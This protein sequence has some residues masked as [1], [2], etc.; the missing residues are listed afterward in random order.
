MKGYLKRNVVLVAFLAI[1]LAL[2]A[3]MICLTVSERNA[4]AAENFTKAGEVSVGH[5]T[6]THYYPFRLCYTDGSAIE[7]DD[8]DYFYNY[9][10]DKSTKMWLE[11]EMI[12]DA[13]LASFAANAPDCVLVSGD[14]AQDGE[15]LGHIDMA[16]KLRKLQNAIRAQ[17]GKENFQI[18][19]VM[20][21]HDLY[22][23]DTF[24][25]DNATGTKTTFYYTTRL[26]AVKIYA[27]LGYPNMTADEATAFYGGLDSN[28]L[29]AGYGY[30][31]SDLSADYA[32]C[33]EFTTDDADGGER[34]FTVNENNKDLIT[35]AKFLA[36]GIIEVE[37]VSRSLAAT[38]GLCYSY[39]KF[40]D[41]KDIGLG[42]MSTVAV[43]ND[44]KFT[45]LALDVVQ[46]NVE[47]G[48][49][50]GGQLHF[51]TWD[52]LE[53]L[54]S[55]ARPN[56][57]AT[58][59]VA[60]A[61]HSLIPHWDMEEDITTGFI[62]YNWV[63]VS[64]FLADY[65]VRYVYTGHQ[66]AN[67]TVSR[68]SFNGNQITDMESS[69]H[70]SVGSQVKV[71]KVEYG[72]AD[73]K[74]AEK[75]Y[76]YAYQNVK[77]DAQSDI[78]LYDR[79]FKDD[80]FGYVAKNNLGEFINDETKEITNYSAYAQRRV[81]DNIVTN[82]VNQFLKPE[83]TEM[84]R[85]LVSD[86]SFNLGPL[87][88]DLG[89]FAGDIVQ[90]A[91]NLISEVNV[92]ILADYEYKGGTERFKPADMKLFGYLEEM[93]FGVLYGEV[94]QGTNVFTVFM[95]SY[96]RHCTGDNWI[97]FNDMPEAYRAVLEK[98]LS[99]EFVDMLFGA[100]LDR[101][102]GLMRLIEGLASTSL[103]LSKDLSRDFTNLINSVVSVLG[104][105]DVNLASF[106]LGAIV[107]AAG[108]IGMITD[109][110][111]G[112]GVK[113]DLAN[114][115]L[116]EIVDDIVAK[117]LTDSFK[118]GL[119]EYAY[120]IVVAFGCDG[121]HVDVKNDEGKLITVYKDEAY[122]FISKERA[123]EITVANGKQPSM[124]TTNF[125]SDPATQR[126]F[127][128]FTD[129]RVT[130]G[131]I[132]YTA[133]LENKTGVTTKDAATAIY[134]T[135][136]PLIDLGIWCQTGY[137]ELSRHTVELTGLTPDTTY[138][139]RAGS[140]DKGYWSEWHT[141]TTAAENGGFEVLVAS[142]LQSSTASAYQRIDSVYREVLASQFAGGLDFLI[143]PGDV[144]DNSRNL[145]HFRWFIDSS[146][147]IYAN[148]PM[149][150]APGN[151]DE[152]H[153]ELD[154]ASHAEY[155]GVSQDAVVTEYNYLWSHYNLVLTESQKQQSGFYY[156]F[157]YSGV[158]FVVLNTNDI[159]TEKVGDA[160]VSKLGQT[161]FN[162][163]V[164]DLAASDAKY[165][166]VI[167]HK[168]LYSEGSHSYD[169]DV[170]G[171]RAQLTP[172]FAEYGVNLVLAGHD[173][174]YNETFYLDA[175]GKKVRTNA[176][177]KNEI[178]D[179]GTLYVT[180]GTLG[181]KFYNYVD[182]PDVP[183]NVGEKLHTD[184]GKL[185]DPTYGKLVFDGEKLYYYG[186]QYLREMSDDGRTVTG[187]QSIEIKKG[188][189]VNAIIAISI[190]SIAAAAV[191]AVVVVVIVKKK[192]AAKSEA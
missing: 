71:T 108:G 4:E 184:D 40:N 98:V 58:L 190:V 132:Q 51:S 168:S 6:D 95:D 159:V 80:K 180:M 23:P 130:D 78:P 41:G 37:D 179:A 153:F 146:A 178:S 111:D 7:T 32:Y 17:S 118:Q 82:Y 157:D 177:K 2:C 68:I 88:I 185:A 110:I 49:V 1:I 93:V 81:Y 48:H 127:T 137:V 14:V 161:Q 192:K 163:L 73:G 116:P 135:T 145:S 175:N 86:L 173:H 142:D 176:N 84:L 62:M 121:G 83:I 188:L 65:G 143:N 134:G 85:G 38:N 39:D 5:I 117:Y 9:I 3:S 42:Q 36:D 112:L 191:I 147:D 70:V 104:I 10:M 101:E 115:T 133:D 75:A 31:R 69:A 8:A 169:N 139:Y 113:I 18:F 34:T 89:K 107:K 187:G 91:D 61:H 60:T 166:V 149:V 29:P 128:Y 140:P 11:A 64:D 114:M 164:A 90:L 154:K 181:E 74:F 55:F 162:W 56:G 20:G 138:A 189:D 148:Y 122:T 22:N 152:K 100:I 26:E 72:T 124:L 46:S 63:E 167:M 172:V 136:K 103:D 15:L 94:A 27:G 171:M 158:H 54:A 79:V 25:F 119:G 97:D 151:H 144:V 59:M 170:M 50:L 21:N 141:F 174:V 77:T 19:V 131:A 45:V 155:Y 109:L 13:G 66:H 156:S 106:N 165:K 186:Y 30:V 183:T 76:L 126:H 105:S 47:E 43:R 120:N 182:N 160:K 125:G 28:D 92:K 16:N 12:L 99:G 102:T 24:R 33:W 129:R 123:E 87:K 53:K 44:G 96:M 35:V 52:W 150:V 57:E 67:D